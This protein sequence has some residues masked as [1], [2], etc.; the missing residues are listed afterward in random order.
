MP[1]QEKE[2]KSVNSFCKDCMYDCK[3]SAEVTVH[4]C[5]LKKTEKEPKKDHQIRL[6]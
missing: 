2:L 5:P 3:Q 4:Y 6:L 1:Q